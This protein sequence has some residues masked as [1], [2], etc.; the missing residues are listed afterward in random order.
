MQ[1]GRAGLRGSEAVWLQKGA[2]VWCVG[3]RVAT[4]KYAPGSPGEA[5]VGVPGQGAG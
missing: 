5:A 4:E 3:R 2:D 1:E